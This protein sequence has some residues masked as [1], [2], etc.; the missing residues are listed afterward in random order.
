MFVV[1]EPSAQMREICIFYARD[2]HDSPFTFFFGFEGSRAE[3]R[4]LE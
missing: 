4:D 2:H 3:M 1:D